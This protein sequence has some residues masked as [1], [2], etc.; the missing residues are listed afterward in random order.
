MKKKQGVLLFW[1]QLAKTSKLTFHAKTL[2][3]EE[4]G[5]NGRG[6]GEVLVAKDGRDVLI[7][8]EKG[9]W[10]NSQGAEINFK[11]VFRWTL[12][13]EAERISLEHLRFGKDHPVF[14]FELAPTGAGSLAST[15]P[16][17]CRKDRYFGEVQVAPHAIHFKWRVVGPHKN[18]AIDYLYF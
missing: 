1:K 16:H 3:P 10:W 8:T 18:E 6:K 11:N 2:L 7:F 17:V 13:R 9:S 5:W 12:H 15:V 14:L 4:H